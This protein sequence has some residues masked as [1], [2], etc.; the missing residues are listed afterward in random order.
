MNS[1]GRSLGLMQ[2]NTVHLT[3]NFSANNIKER[4]REREMKPRKRKEDRTSV[5]IIT[6]I[7]I[8]YFLS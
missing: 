8:M 4:E 5:R 3:H 1:G 2:P 6:N 7:Y